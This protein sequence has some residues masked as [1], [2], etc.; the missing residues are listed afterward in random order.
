MSNSNK[1]PKNFNSYDS[2]KLSFEALNLLYSELCSQYLNLGDKMK[3]VKGAMV[4]NQFPTEESFIENVK[5]LAKDDIHKAYLFAEHWLGCFK[6]KAE[7]VVIEILLS[8]ANIEAI[9]KELY[10]FYLQGKVCEAII[11]YRANT[12]LSLVDSKTRVEAILDS[13]KKNPVV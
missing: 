6:S 9:N 12:G 8:N 11:Y 7:E 10:R 3:Q 2:R 4:R 5:V 13:F 1:F